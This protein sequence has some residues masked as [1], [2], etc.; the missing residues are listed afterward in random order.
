MGKIIQIKK[1]NIT[2]GEKMY[3]D[4]LCE[5]RKKPKD[6]SDMP[7]R[8]EEVLEKFNVNNYSLG[9]PI[10]DILTKLGFEI[11]QSNLKPDGLSAYIAVNPEFEDLYGSN[12]ITC[13]HIKKSVGHKRFALAHE[14]GHYFFNCN[15]NE[16]IPYYNTY[17]PGSEGN[18]IDEKRANKF[19]ANLL[20]PE[21]EF[22][23]KF[24]EYNGL[25]SKAD[26][27]KALEKYFV[28]SSTA[29]LKRF[30]ELGI[31]KFKNTVET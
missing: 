26:I 5:I 9:V 17:F 18:D 10:V 29:I 28:V 7:K 24:E 19:A 6:I 22:R 31:D 3:R 27:V 13:V 4:F 23:K 1:Y 21:R 20:M 15:E 8:A 14:L 11:F 16:C 12:K 2:K 30:D 25:Q